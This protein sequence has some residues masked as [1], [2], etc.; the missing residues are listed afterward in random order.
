MKLIKITM[1]VI[2][3]GCLCASCATQSEMKSGKNQEDLSYN[4]KY[5]NMPPAWGGSFGGK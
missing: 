2:L 5:R 4:Y 1:L 3:I